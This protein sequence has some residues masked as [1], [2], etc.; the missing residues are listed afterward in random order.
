MASLFIESEW[1]G[2]GKE[3]N[4]AK[5]PEHVSEAKKQLLKIPDTVEAMIPNNTMPLVA[6]YEISLH[7]NCPRS[8]WNS[9]R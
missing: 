2:L 8:H 5:I 3:Y 9:Y 7:I 6:L 4:I 1:I